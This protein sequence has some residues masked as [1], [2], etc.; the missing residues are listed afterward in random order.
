MN[1]PRGRVKRR[2]WPMTKKVRGRRVSEQPTRQPRDLSSFDANIAVD[3]LLQR[4][5]VPDWDILLVGDGSGNT[6]SAPCGWSCVL[7]DRQ[8][9]GRKLFYGG[10]NAGSNYLAEAMP[11]LHAL[12]W[13]DQ[14]RGQGRIEK[15]GLQRVALIT[16]SEALYH[17]LQ[18]PAPS[19][20]RIFWGAWNELKRLGYHIEPRWLRRST[21]QL[22]V[23]ADMVAGK[24]RRVMLDAQG[25][26]E[27][28][29]A[30]FIR[31]QLQGLEIVDPTT[32]STVDLGSVNPG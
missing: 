27:A 28:E 8:T 15:F 29:R 2:D 14:D 12:L 10:L 16:D 19:A 32:G 24:S 22:N 23:L 7:I 3:E 20:L 11:Y 9:R 1:S 4:M 13:Y 5:N 31:E 25:L 18:S 26:T 30:R 21:I 6:W 17:G